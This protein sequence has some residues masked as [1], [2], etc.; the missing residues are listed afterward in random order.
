MLPAALGTGVVAARHESLGAGASWVTETTLD[1]FLQLADAAERTSQIGLG[2]AVAVAFGRSPMTVAVT[3]NHLQLLSRG[4]FL[5]GL[6]T[7]VRAHVERRYSMTWSEPA[8]RMR[9]YVGA[10]R[11]IW[12]SWNERVPL[13]FRGRFYSH[14]L[15]PPLFDPGPNPHGPPRV[16]LGGVRETMV[17][18]VGEVADGFLVP[19]LASKRYLVERQLPAL[20]EG[21]RRTHDGELGVEICAMPMVVTGR[22]D[23]E[24]ANAYEATR[25]RI[26]FYASTPTYASVFELHGWGATREQLSDLARRREWKS[27]ASLVTDEIV[28]TLAVVAPADLL[29]TA[30]SA[31]YA[32]CAGR[33]I[34]YPIDPLP[35]VVEEE[36]FAG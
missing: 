23:T 21:W 16:Y 26:A 11:A 14:T 15:L 33:A 3:A 19:P 8:A 22:D 24:V 34:L 31:R 35:G 1:P 30:V 4:R 2:T 36:V 17:E 5:L 18:V 9:E 28:E 25:A 6:G 7:Q 10:L 13:D 32:D 20:T 27:M 12:R 29:L